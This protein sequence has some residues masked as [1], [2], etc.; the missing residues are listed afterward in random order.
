MTEVL[1]SEIA[2]LKE[3]CDA[4]TKLLE[5]KEKAKA[6]ALSKIETDK[7]YNDINKIYNQR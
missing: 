4:R 2:V 3:L 6:N 5:E 1:N 7:A